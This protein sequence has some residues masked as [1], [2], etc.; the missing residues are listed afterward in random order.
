MV[1]TK[2]KIISTTSFNFTIGVMFFGTPHS[3]ADSRGMLQRV[4]E[5]VIKAVGYSVDEQIVSSLLPSAER[6]QELRDDFG[7]RAQQQKRIVHSFQEQSSITFLGGHKASA[8]NYL[9]ILLIRF[10][11]RR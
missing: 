2:A 6:L 7:P 5:K 10:A 1:T 11:G 9:T 4:A 8:L 3:G